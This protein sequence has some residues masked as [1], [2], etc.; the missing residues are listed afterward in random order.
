MLASTLAPVVASIAS[1]I[2]MFYPLKSLGSVLSGTIG[3][4][5]TVVYLITMALMSPRPLMSDKTF[6][7]FLIVST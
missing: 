6:G 2:F 1:F 7:K 5:V 4:L 3:Y